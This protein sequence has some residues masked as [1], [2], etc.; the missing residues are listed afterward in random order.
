MTPA[1]QRCLKGCPGM[2]FIG[3]AVLYASAG[4]T[5]RNHYQAPTSNASSLERHPRRLPHLG[6]TTTP[7]RQTPAPA[8]PTSAWPPT[9]PRD[10]ATPI[11]G[12]PS[13]NFRVVTFITV[14][15]QRSCLASP[16]APDLSRLS[17]RALDL[18]VSLSD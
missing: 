13:Q 7:P 10:P 11:T 2:V 12:M 9:R 4:S 5:A 18:T 8:H 17:R 1:S 16:M 3:G 15:V 6:A 14:V